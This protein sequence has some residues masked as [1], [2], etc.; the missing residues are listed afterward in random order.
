MG[1]STDFDLNTCIDIFVCSLWAC[2]AFLV[3]LTEE[4][5]KSIKSGGVRLDLEKRSIRN[6]A[7]ARKIKYGG[8]DLSI[9]N[10][11]LSP[12]HTLCI[13]LILDGWGYFKLSRQLIT[14]WAPLSKVKADIEA[15]MVPGDKPSTQVWIC[16]LL[17]KLS[18]DI[19]IALCNMVQVMVQIM[20]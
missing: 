12:C 3:I 16:P 6:I 2:V 14:L 15:L 7:K 19:K 9:L 18:A 8:H 20:L 10:V 17:R 13:I 5:G 4:E 1:Q 11:W